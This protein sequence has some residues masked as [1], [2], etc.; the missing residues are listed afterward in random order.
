MK[1]QESMTVFYKQGYASGNLNQAMIELTRKDH[2]LVLM[3]KTN[4]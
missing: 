1:L 4:T 2:T 3:Q